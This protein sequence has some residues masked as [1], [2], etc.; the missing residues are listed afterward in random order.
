MPVHN[1]GTSHSE[2]TFALQRVTPPGEMFST[3]GGSLLRVTFGRHAR[4]SQSGRSRK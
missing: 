4:N 3:L 2:N 1:A